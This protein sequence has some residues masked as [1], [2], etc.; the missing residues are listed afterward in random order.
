M[1]GTRLSSEGPADNYRCYTET[2]KKQRAHVTKRSHSSKGV[3]ALSLG[4]H[5]GNVI[6]LLWHSCRWAPWEYTVWTSKTTGQPLGTNDS[7][8]TLRPRFKFLAQAAW[9]CVDTGHHPFFKKKAVR[10]NKNPRQSVPAKYRSMGVGGVFFQ[11]H[12]S[13]QTNEN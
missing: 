10:T 3:F 6:A 4:V 7:L 2:P 12:F 5:L 1:T 9:I 8:P 13:Q 11:Q